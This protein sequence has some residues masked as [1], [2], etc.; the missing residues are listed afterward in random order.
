MLGRRGHTPNRAKGGGERPTD[1]RPGKRKSR[2]SKNERTS[3][4][5]KKEGGP[6]LMQ[7]ADDASRIQGGRNRIQLPIALFVS[8]THLNIS[9][10]SSFSA[11]HFWLPGSRSG[12]AR[13]LKKENRITPEEN[14][15]VGRPDSA[16]AQAAANDTVGSGKRG[17]GGSDGIFFCVCRM[18]KKERL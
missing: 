9:F 3:P 18:G 4:I 12:S 7:S 17:G 10:L 14:K 16:R 11:R 2:P 15:W 5:K 8:L 13:T 1:H 6:G